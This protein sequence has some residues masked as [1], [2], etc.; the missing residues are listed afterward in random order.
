MVKCYSPVLASLKII[1][2][3]WQWDHTHDVRSWYA[4]VPSISN[5]ADEPSRMRK[6]DL[7][8][9]CNCKFVQLVFP[10][11]TSP[12]MTLFP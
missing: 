12:A 6:G 7:C 2:Q 11:G 9:L 8:T 4:R 3:S 1:V 5:V 10:P